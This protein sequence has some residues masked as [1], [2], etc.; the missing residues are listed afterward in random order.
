MKT[1]CTLEISPV[2][3]AYAQSHIGM[4]NVTR[5][6]LQLLMSTVLFFSETPS[7]ARSQDSSTDKE[8]SSLLSG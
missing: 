6:E 3:F 2:V 7:T 8:N 4:V 1:C 5:H